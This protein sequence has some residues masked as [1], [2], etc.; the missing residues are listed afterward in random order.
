MNIIVACTKELG[1]GLKNNLPWQ[2]RKE[3]LNFKEKTLNGVVVMGRK[4][5]ESIPKKFRPLKDRVNIVLTRNKDFVAKGAIIVS[6]TM[7][8][9]SLLKQYQNQQIWI[10]GGAELYKQYINK[11]NQ[12]HVSYITQKNGILIDCDTFF[13]DIPENFIKIE[14]IKG[15]DQM[16]FLEYVVYNK[17]L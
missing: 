4:T 6:S 9:D 16:Y 3:M 17:N 5:W 1:I 2:S 10:I 14:S 12:I 7:E 8:L 15:S 11:V 13:P